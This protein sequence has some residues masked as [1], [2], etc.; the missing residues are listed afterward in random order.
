MLGDRH[1]VGIV[2]VHAHGQGLD[3]ARNQKAI[4]GREAR[5][6]RALYEI[7]LLGFFRARE[8]YR[9]AGA[10]AVAVQIFGHGMD[11]DVRAQRERLLEIRA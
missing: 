1:S 4:H 3:A 9:A 2:A 8:D 6:R 11:H 5:A 7:Y 10:V